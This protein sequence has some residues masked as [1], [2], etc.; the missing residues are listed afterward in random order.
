MSDYSNDVPDEEPVSPSDYLTIND[1]SAKAG[2]SSE[3]ARK[4]AKDMETE[5]RYV[6]GSPHERKLIVIHRDIW[7][8]YKQ[9]KGIVEIGELVQ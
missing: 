2:I 6:E 9:K 3:T 4:W 8:E 1:I 5:W 7:N